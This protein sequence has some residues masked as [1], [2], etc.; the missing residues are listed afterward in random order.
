MN[1]ILISIV[2]PIYNVEKYLKQCI[3]SIINQTYK[4]IEILLVNDGSTD[5]CAQ[6]C[7]EYA[8]I[9]ERIKVIHKK[10]GGLSDARNSGINIAKGKY[11]AFIDSDD[12]VSEEYIEK[13]YNAI[14]ENNVRIA[15]C[16]FVKVTDDNTEIEKIGYAE[17]NKI[18]SGYEM[19]KELYTGHWENILAWNKLY[20]IGLF[21]NVRYPFGKIH[22]DEFTTY[23]I[24]YEIQNVAIVEDC[25]YKYRQNDNSITGQNFKKKRLDVIIAYE[26]RM[27]FFEKNDEEELYQLSL[28]SYLGTIR[29]CYEKTRRYL[30]E[31][32]NIQ[33][34]LIK[35]Y[36]KNCVKLRK[37]KNINK[38]EKI[39]ILMFYFLPNMYYMIKS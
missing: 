32:Q 2:V 29:R 30:K 1:D 3:E 15:Q 4:N 18:K 9:D 7:D 10:N 34:D 27:E 8:Q 14:S 5:N 22:E 16:N 38:I 28:I 21:K 12:Y 13:L 36:R 19:V 23:K 26:E 11:I 35:K 24:L 39:K 17:K 25:L 31:S 20:D 6:I 37:I 33:K